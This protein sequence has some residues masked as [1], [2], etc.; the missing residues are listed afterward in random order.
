MSFNPFEEKPVSMDC[1]FMDWATINPK[2]YNKETT[3]PY[4]KTRIVLMNGTEFEAQG[5]SRNFSRHC[6]DNDLRR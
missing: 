2:P 6:P 3:D 4:T 5:F 1:L